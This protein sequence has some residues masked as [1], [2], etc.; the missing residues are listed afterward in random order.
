[1]LL[2]SEGSQ[3]ALIVPPLRNSVATERDKAKAK[4]IKM[5]KKEAKIKAVADSKAREDK[6]NAARKKA[7]LRAQKKAMSQLKKEMRS[8]AKAISRGDAGALDGHVPRRSKKSSNLETFV[9]AFTLTF[10]LNFLIYYLTR[11]G[12]LTSLFDI[13]ITLDFNYGLNE[14]GVKIFASTLVPIFLILKLSQKKTRVRARI[15]L[16][17]TKIRL[18][19]LFKWLLDNLG[20]ISIRALKIL[21][22]VRKAFG[23]WSENLPEVL[24]TLIDWTGEKL[25]KISNWI[26]RRY[27]LIR[28]FLIEKYDQ[29]D[30]SIQ[31]SRKNRAQRREAVNSE[32]SFA[33]RKIRH[34]KADGGM[35][36]VFLARDRDS[37]E[38]VIWK[39]ASPSRKNTLESVNR[40]I[41]NEVEMLRLIN[42]PRVPRYID[43]GFVKNDDDETVQVLIMEYIDGMSL[44][45]EMMVFQNSQV[46]PPL[47]R[48][49]ELLIQCCE[50]LEDLADFN[51][52]IYHRDIKPH[53]IITT[54]EKGLVLIDFGLAKEIDSGDGVSLSAGAHS[55]G[56]SP[57]E[58]TRAI[59]GGFTDVY[60][61]G[62]ILWHMLT[63]E[64]AGIYPEEYRIEKIE[65]SGHPNWLSNLV[66][67]STIPSDAKKRIQSAAEFRMRL[68]NEGELP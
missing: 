37:G 23:E 29:L 2:G 24:Q 55:E 34:L 48:V 52:P 50:V 9:I 54:P 60:G 10:L 35:A 11:E 43:S 25:S 7:K 4:A 36:E 53:N 51:P 33:Y 16:S 65:S 42:H 13:P 18:W 22:R 3:R 20:K 57:P 26:S 15:L 39:Q 67:K 59:S 30:S 46:L 56:W 21:R 1:M 38:N 6:K 32:I 64:S 28:K 19:D 62:Q 45:Q 12:N 66:N 31:R 63:N 17:E 68:E 14:F 44:N 47:N 58:R 5:L 41:E 27:A 49:I 8:R 61:M 40:S